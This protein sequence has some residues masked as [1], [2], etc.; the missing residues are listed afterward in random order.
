MYPEI[1]SRG[2]GP[3]PEMIQVFHLYILIVLDELHTLIKLRPL[4]ECQIPEL[5][6][7]EFGNFAQKW[8]FFRKI[9]EIRYM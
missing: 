7:F 8:H 6:H 2:G 3:I 4:N 5:G 1:S 9:F